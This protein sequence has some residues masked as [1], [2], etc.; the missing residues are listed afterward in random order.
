VKYLENNYNTT[1]IKCF[2][3][4][5]CNVLYSS[6]ICDPR[7]HE[8]QVSGAVLSMVLGVLILVYWYLI[9]QFV[10]PRF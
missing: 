4:F 2:K 10:I 8:S 5:T 7:L 6:W 1:F 3:A 9:G